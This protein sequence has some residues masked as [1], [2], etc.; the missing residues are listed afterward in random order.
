[1]KNKKSLLSVLLAAVLLCACVA[2]MLVFGAG[3]EGTV[4][5]YYVDANSTGTKTAPATTVVGEKEILTF[6]TIR[7][8]TAYAKNFC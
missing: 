8:A 3:A 1:M 5:T 6:K 2:G 7:D 4:T